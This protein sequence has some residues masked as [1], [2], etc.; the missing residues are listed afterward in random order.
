M[1]SPR[2]FSWLVGTSRSHLR[3]RWSSLFQHTF[4][5]RAAGLFEALTQ[6]RS[7][8]MRSWLHQWFGRPSTVAARGRRAKP[9]AAGR[10]EHVLLL[11]EALE[12]RTLLSAPDPHVIPTFSE[13]GA[14][15]FG[16]GSSTLS[17]SGFLGGDFDV[18]GTV[19][20]I[21]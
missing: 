13:Q 6:P 11:L 7:L 18:N 2:P 12:N 8:M 14:S 5:G 1:A 17:G 3:T 19:G 9:K 21:S 16:G 15:Q 20:D 10:R 4:L